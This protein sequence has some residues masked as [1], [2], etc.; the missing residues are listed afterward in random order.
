MTRGAALL[1]AL[2]FA[3]GAFLHGGIWEYGDG[4]IFNRFNG[5]VI[6]VEIPGADEAVHLA[7]DP[8]VPAGARRGSRHP[9]AA[10]L[11]RSVRGHRSELA[12]V[13]SSY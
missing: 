5:R 3:V 7:F 12:R 6:Y 9:H 4:F 1:I 2:G 10:H 13:R 8:G 11:A